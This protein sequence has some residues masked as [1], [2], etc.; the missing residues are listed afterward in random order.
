METESDTEAEEKYESESEWHTESDELELESEES[1]EE[2]ELELESE[3]ELEHELS[4]EEEEDSKS[5]SSESESEESWRSKPIEELMESDF[6]RYDDDP[7]PYHFF[8]PR[9]EY[10]NKAQ[11]K[12]DGETEK[13]VAE[14]VERT[15]NLSPFDAIPVPPKANKFGNNWAKP[16]DITNHELHTRLIHLSNLALAKYNARNDQGARYVFEKL[17]KATSRFI[18]ISTYYITFEAKDATHVDTSN[19]PAI[20]FQAHVWDRTLSEKPSVVKS[21]SIKPT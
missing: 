8:C 2:S 9:F 16:T 4:E 19:C 1:E 14:Y 18:P 3:S 12:L 11:K 5:E 20:I 21:C 10:K 15:R 13:A 17:V 6:Y 7:A